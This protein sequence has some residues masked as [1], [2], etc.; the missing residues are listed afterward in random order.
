MATKSPKRAR[1]LQ[2]NKTVLFKFTKSDSTPLTSGI[3]RKM[4]V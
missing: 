4:K 2:P 1:A 3:E